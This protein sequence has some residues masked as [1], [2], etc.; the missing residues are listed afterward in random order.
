TTNPGFGRGA[1]QR[2]FRGFRSTSFDGRWGCVGGGGALAGWTRAEDARHR[3]LAPVAADLREHLDWGADSQKF[4]LAHLRG[5]AGSRIEVGRI[6][7][8]APSFANTAEGNAAAAVLLGALVRRL[9]GRGS[10]PG[11]LAFRVQGPDLHG[12]HKKLR[13]D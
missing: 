3:A 6:P 2:P 1:A 11:A 13:I 8:I 10:Y 9:Q 7:G 12:A 4:E 5:T